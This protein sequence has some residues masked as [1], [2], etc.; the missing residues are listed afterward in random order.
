[1]AIKEE[2]EKT[3]TYATQK[4]EDLKKMPKIAINV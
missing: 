4:K 2:S 3:E 1:M